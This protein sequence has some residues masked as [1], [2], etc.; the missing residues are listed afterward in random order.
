M[1]NAFTQVLLF[2][3]TNDTDRIFPTFQ[4]AAKLFKGK[5]IKLHLAFDVNYTGVWFLTEG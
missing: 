4:E 2:A 1:V 3:T 5:V